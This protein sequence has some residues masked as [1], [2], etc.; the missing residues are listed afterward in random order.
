M[1]KR[2]YYEVL[3]V[4]RDATNDAIKEAYRRLALQYHPDRNPGNKEAEEKF[5]EATEAYEVLSDPQK[6]ATYD[7]FGFQGVE[8]TGFTWTD[9]LSRVQREFGD[10]FGH[11]FFDDLFDL[12]GGGVETRTKQRGGG[13]GEDIETVVTVSLK[14]VSEDTEKEIEITRLDTCPVCSGTG[15][16]SAGTRTCPQCSGT[17]QIYYQQGF[18]AITRTC[19]KCNGSGQIIEK[20]CRNCNGKGRVRK[21][22]KLRVTIPAGIESGSKLRVRGKG[23]VGIRGGPSGNLYL[24]I[25]IE[26][27]PNFIR[28][29]PNLIYQLYVTFTEAALGTEREVPTLKGSVRMKIPAGTQS[30]TIFRLRGKGL[31]DIDGLRRGDQLVR[32]MVETPV[33]LRYEERQLL[34]ELEE[35]TGRQCYPKSKGG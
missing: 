7:R 16:A 5:K 10:I 23:N 17:G 20:P 21:K 11:G 14:E 33:N 31:P 4:S 34:K 15:S 35:R 13:R 30:S 2:D 22:E 29:G 25:L 24:N 8:S 18:F 19:P 3:G 26:K 6:R 28:E 1:A 32:V 9:D 27:D 12:F